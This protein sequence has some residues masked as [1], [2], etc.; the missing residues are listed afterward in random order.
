ML[1]DLTHG[2]LAFSF[3]IHPE[4]P[5]KKKKYFATLVVNRVEIYDGRKIKI[6]N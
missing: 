4:L 3:P 6:Q 1:D 2:N 5:L